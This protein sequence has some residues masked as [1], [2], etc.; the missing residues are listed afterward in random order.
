MNE[1]ENLETVTQELKSLIKRASRE[2]SAAG[3]GSFELKVKVDH[4]GIRY[5]R[6]YDGRPAEQ[7]DFL[8]G[9]ELPQRDPRPAYLEKAE[10]DRDEARAAF[11]KV[12]ALYQEALDEHARKNEQSRGVMSSPAHVV[13]LLSDSPEIIV[14]RKERETAWKQVVAANIA[15][16][17]ASKRRQIEKEEAEFALQKR[18]EEEKKAEALKRHRQIVGPVLERLRNRLTGNA[19]A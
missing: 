12:D 19:T 2:R 14:A 18:R 13:K 9:I 8:T 16:D 5:T 7:A 17:Q 4:G 15:L 11:D 1:Q 6:I 10:R 3:D